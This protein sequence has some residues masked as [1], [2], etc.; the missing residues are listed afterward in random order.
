MVV[1]GVI[2]ELSPRSNAEAA[3]GDRAPTAS[4]EQH[5]IPEWLQPQTEGLVEGASESSGSAGETI[6][7]TPSPHIPARPSNKSGGKLHLFID[8]RKTQVFF[9]LQTHKN[10]ESSMQK[11][12]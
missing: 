12:S 7:K 8:F 3:L 5:E 4:G 6:L 9:Y 1:L 10:H 11:D 2:V